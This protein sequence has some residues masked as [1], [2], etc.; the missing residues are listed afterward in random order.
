[1]D[2]YNVGDIFILDGVSYIAK[3]EKSEE[4]CSGCVLDGS[5][6]CGDMACSDKHVIYEIYN[7][8]D[9]ASKTSITA[10]TSIDY[11]INE[12]ISIYSELNTAIREG[13]YDD[14]IKAI[15]KL[16]KFIEK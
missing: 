14:R 13:F 11:P 3:L 16:R 6:K 1:M 7:L 12:L 4:S 10:K 15:D 8:E 2:S 9:V 5:Y